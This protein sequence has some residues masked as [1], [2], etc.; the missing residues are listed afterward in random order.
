MALEELAKCSRPSPPQV[1]ASSQGLMVV[2]AAL[3]RLVKRLHGR[4]KLPS[5]GE[6]GG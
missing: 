1:G 3:E 2:N 5:Q 4:G 6:Q